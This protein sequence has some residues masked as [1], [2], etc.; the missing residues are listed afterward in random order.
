[1]VVGVAPAATTGLVRVR[2]VGRWRDGLTDGGARQKNQIVHELKSP[3][4][5]TASFPGPGDS[6]VRQEDGGR[7]GGGR[8]R[9]MGWD[10]G[11]VR[12]LA[13]WRFGVQVLYTTDTQA[14]T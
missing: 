8:G 3:D 4:L 5:G 6:G 14:G 2:V 1:M 13:G 9:D 7:T 10:R 11:Q 12:G